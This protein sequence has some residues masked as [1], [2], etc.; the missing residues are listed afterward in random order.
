MYDRYLFKRIMYKAVFMFSENFV[1]NFRETEA[2]SYIDIIKRIMVRI[3]PIQCF[4]GKHLLQLMPDIDCGVWCV[5]A[6]HCVK[7]TVSNWSSF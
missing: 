4:L 6:L 2:R 5:S 1:R 7:F 3:S